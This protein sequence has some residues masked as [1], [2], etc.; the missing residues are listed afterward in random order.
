MEFEP[1]ILAFMC[2]WCSY[3]AADAAGVGRQEY[4]PYHRV[5]RVMCSGR[6]DPLFVISA[7]KAGAD[8]V[9][10]AGCNLGECHYV[11]C[12]FQALVM[13]E[14]VK[15]LMRLIG[16]NT[17]RFKFEWV[18]SA[19]PARLVNDLKSFFQVVK[20]LGPLGSSEGLSP[21][22]LK[23]R[24]GCAELVCQNMQVRATYGNIA[25]E[26]KKLSDFSAETIKQ[27]VEEKLEKLI[28][29]KFYKTEIR[30][31]LRDGPKSI[32]YLT[33]KTGAEKG[34]LEEILAKVV[35]A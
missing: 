31:L 28:K 34:L 30:E 29:N 11:D 24:L 5:I 10:V 7:F 9:I 4:P 3:G 33:Q 32:D 2:H 12:N 26:L 13:G 16:L 8:G 1:R 18:S 15:I 21:E 14:L 23:F 20:A 19:E 22:D 35:K 17:E 27:K 25:K 6:V